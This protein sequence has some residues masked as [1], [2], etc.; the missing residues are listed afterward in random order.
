M[1]TAPALTTTNQQPTGRALA[2]QRIA[3]G[4]SLSAVA[5]MA[6]FHP[7]DLQRC[8]LS[9]ATLSPARLARWQDALRACAE[10]RAATLRREG[11]ALGELP[12]DLRRTLALY[13]ASA[14]D[15]GRAQP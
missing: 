12:R 10:K 2:R 6:G 14:G 15:G 3:L 9:D 4:L 13:V 1:H 11:W 8:E 5:R 7:H